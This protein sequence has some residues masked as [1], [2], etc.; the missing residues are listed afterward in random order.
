MFFRIHNRKIRLLDNFKLFTNPKVKI[1]NIHTKCIGNFGNTII[2]V[3][4]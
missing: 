2:N 4:F 3:F 1:T